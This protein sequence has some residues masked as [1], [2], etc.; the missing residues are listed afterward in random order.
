MEIIESPDAPSHSGP[1]PQAVRA[2]DF[3]YVSAIFGS[4]PVTDE[5]PAAAQ[6]EARLLLQHLG[7]IVQEA[8]G[9]LSDVV[10]VGIYCKELQ[11]DRPAFNRA[12]V[13]MFGDHRPARSAV[14][15]NE[16][17]RPGTNF[18]FMVEAV[19]YLGE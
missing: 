9:S 2:G 19:A 16:F 5:I 1:V 11:R 13:Q 14:G 12:W 17:G 4:D 6:D 7:S 18:R 10:R 15:V 8:G 3:L